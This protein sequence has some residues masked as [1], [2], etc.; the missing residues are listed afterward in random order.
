MP[1]CRAIEISRGSY[2]GMVTWLNG[3]LATIPCGPT[4]GLFE[5]QFY[6]LRLIE[7]P[8]REAVLPEKTVYFRGIMPYIYA[9]FLKF[10]IVVD[11]F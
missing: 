5:K 9:L 1:S 11:D 4:E 10:R 7:F 2:G 8:A 3:F 6:H